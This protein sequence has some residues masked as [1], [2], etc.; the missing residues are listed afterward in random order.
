MCLDSTIRSLFDDFE[1]T[2]KNPTEA[3]ARKCSKRSCKLCLESLVK[4]KSLLAYSLTTVSEMHV[5]EWSVWGFIVSTR[6]YGVV[7][8]IHPG[9]LRRGDLS[10]GRWFASACWGDMSVAGFWGGTYILRGLFEWLFNFCFSGVF[11]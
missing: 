3:A 9:C 7:A 2:L 8:V 10:G 6:R 5:E 4:N 11:C 1:L